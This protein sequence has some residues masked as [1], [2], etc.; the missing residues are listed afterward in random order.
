MIKHTGE[1]QSHRYYPNTTF[2]NVCMCYS[3]WDD[4]VV[5]VQLLNVWDIWYI[6]E[7]FLI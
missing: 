3:S 6:H 7:G 2:V 5:Y 1:A 4:M